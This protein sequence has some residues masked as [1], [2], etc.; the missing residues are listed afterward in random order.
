VG[1]EADTD[2]VR[3]VEIFEVLIGKWGSI[4]DQLKLGP[5]P[6]CHQPLCG[7]GPGTLLL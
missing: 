6:W 2:A 1:T 3:E 4:A 5:R 7:C